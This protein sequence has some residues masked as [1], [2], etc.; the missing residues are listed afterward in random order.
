MRHSR[1]KIY[2]RWAESVLQDFVVSEDLGPETLGFAHRVAMSYL[3][4]FVDEG[5]FCLSHRFGK[6]TGLGAN[7]MFA[8]LDA[9]EPFRRAGLFTVD[10]STLRRKGRRRV[11][12]KIQYIFT[13]KFYEL[14]RLKAPKQ[15]NQSLWRSMGPRRT[16]FRKRV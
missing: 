7:S 1:S 11:G 13:D 3:L 12:Q 14:I 9:V 8:F 4:R 10:D 5:R 15:R 16:L 2:E 6:L